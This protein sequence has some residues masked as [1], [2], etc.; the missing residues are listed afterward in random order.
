MSSSIVESD[1]VTASQSVQEWQEF[2]AQAD[3]DWDL[4]VQEEMRVRTEV[5][6][7][8]EIEFPSPVISEDV[9]IEKDVAV[10]M[11]DGTVLRA[12][13]YRPN[14]EGRF[15]VV[16]NRGPYDKTASLD[17]TPAV[18]R[19]LAK[20]GYVGLAQ[21]VRG[22]YASDGEFVAGNEVDDGVDTVEW[23]ATQTWSSGK[24]GMFGISYNGLVQILAAIGQAKH[25]TCIFPGMIDFSADQTS[26]GV[27]QLQ[28]VASWHIWAGQGRE[29]GN[30]LR[31]DYRHLP[32]VEID[33]KS[34]TPN[35]VF[36]AMVANNPELNKSDQLSG[37]N[38]DMMDQLLS[39][40]RTKTYYALG[41]YDVFVDG[42]IDAW[43]QIRKVVPDAKIMIG[44]YHHNLCDM[45]MPRMGK[46]ETKDVELKRY[47][48]QME[49]FF[50]H[51]LKGEVNEVS[52]NKFA[53]KL[54][55]MG[56]N[57]WRDE[58]D[59]PL[60]RAQYKSLYLSSNG[61]A[62]ANLKDGQ[63]TWDNP[64]DEQPTD[65]YSYDPLNPV[66]W[67]DKLDPWSYLN[68]MGSRNEVEA[69]DDVLVYSTP[70]LTEELEV[71]GNVTMKL[72]AASS[73]P[74]TDFVATLVDVH[75][76]GHTQ[77]LTQGIVRARYR[78][79]VDNESLIEPGKVY[80]YDIKM[81]AT[82]NLFKKG[83][84]L[85]LEISSSEFS[86]WARNQNVAD[87]QGMTDNTQIADQTIY[88]GA[89]ELSHLVIPVIPNS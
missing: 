88:H 24:V 50:A 67:S 80:E 12:D 32:L 44:P 25:L 46:V 71:T 10:T 55:V 56:K 7:S 18:L 3:K 86:K 66:D 59:W 39:M 23:A 75:P 62:A 15:P 49:M 54:F 70:V 37:L 61:Q 22:R 6:P 21:D 83:H 82:C 76:N 52:R 31:T 53:V 84:Q 63:L 5:L 68:E 64:V 47:Y 81:Q 58:Q 42:T 2:Q 1:K 38:Q 30:P 4:V 16:I 9:I 87:A 28:S 11:R 57:E 19:S 27:P 51:H 26:G 48:E 36:D 43:Q 34:G 60:A 77:Y 40:V 29:A 45:E 79:G 85:R 72:F 33:D 13:I 35:T 78:N 20:R 73:A 74:D 17:F 14:L 41:W 69:R 65:K 8:K 89:A